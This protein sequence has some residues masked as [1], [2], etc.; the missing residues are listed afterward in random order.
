MQE[1]GE[2]LVLSDKT[3]Y[4]P[5]ESRSVCFVYRQREYEQKIVR[6]EKTQPY[7]RSIKKHL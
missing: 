7:E 1:F 5:C 4:G 6:S 3:V 2:D